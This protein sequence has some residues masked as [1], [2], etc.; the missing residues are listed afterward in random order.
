MITSVT[1]NNIA[2]W[3]W[4]HTIN[5]NEWINI[6]DW[7]RGA[8]KS[9]LL[10]DS[11]Q[12]VLT[13]TSRTTSFENIITKGEEEGSIQLYFTWVD[14]EKYKF[15]WYHKLKSIK[16]IKDKKTWL[17]KET[18]V[19]AKTIWEVL[20]WD[21]TKKEYEKSFKSP[22]QV[23]GIPYSIASKT[24][25]VKQKDIEGFSKAGPTEK[26]DI[27]A[28]SF[29][30]S[31]LFSIWEKASEK[32][33]KL[34]I[35]KNT[36]L[37]DLK[38]INTAD[39]DKLVEIEKSYNSLKK[40]QEKILLEENT[41]SKSREGFRNLQFEY[42]QIILK[43]DTIK[44]NE[45]LIIEF[46]KINLKEVEDK[47]KE[48]K[49]KIE[50]EWNDEIEKLENKFIILKSK[51]DHL[52][53]TY[54]SKI[55]EL[56][57]MKNMRERNFIQELTN[58]QK[59]FIET[60]ISNSEVFTEEY[61]Q[62]LEK[63][64]SD[65]LSTNL[66]KVNENLQNLLSNLK[67]LNYKIEENTNIIEK[68]KSLKESSCPTCYRE[69]SEE[70]KK[71][72]IKQFDSTKKEKEKE[73][74]VLEKEKEKLLKSKQDLEENITN[75]WLYEKYKENKKY[76]EDWKTKQAEYQKFKTEEEEK[77]TKLK[78]ESRKEIWN[79]TSEVV[80]LQ[81]KIEE[82]KEKSKVERYKEE[83][84]EIEFKT[85]LIW[86]KTYTREEIK[87]TIR[88]FKDQIREYKETIK[89]KEQELKIESNKDYTEILTNKIEE[90]NSK[91][92][93]LQEEKNNKSEE[94]FNLNTQITKLKG[95]KERYDK[96]KDK[97]ESLN[98]NLEVLEKIWTIFWKKWHPKTIIEQ[99]IIP[100]L[101]LKTNQILKDITD[102]NYNVK[103]S[104]SS[105]TADWRESKKNIFDIIVFI[106][107]IEQ[108]YDSISG[109]EQMLVNYAMRL[110]ITECLNEILGKKVSD[111]LVLDEAFTAVESRLNAE[112]IL[113]SI[114][115]TSK[116]FKQ[117]FIITHETEL[118]EGL[119]WSST[120]FPI[121]KEG[122]YSK[123]LD[124]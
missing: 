15:Y 67:V 118:K 12:I 122:R 119:Q 74:L 41:L 81:T 31:T 45:D 66:V 18:T 117:I 10:V 16:K 62:K 90:I 8:W 101:E 94:I 6:L 52:Q 49:E 113:T 102:W 114:K 24:F 79:M 98:W 82:L 36:L 104:L 107:W 100:Q 91:L 14:W 3:K 70:E 92:I 20:E 25:I 34:I 84:K 32:I 72:I 123:I 61:C 120:I 13:N 30:I 55:K 56:E 1:V 60:K 75:I 57:S 17:D 64:K 86:D 54:D 39:F 9:S 103:F 121:V 19:W 33:K 93:K 58:L 44:K 51:K 109:W 99:M 35:E 69:L 77:I 68:I 116:L 40:E 124:N 28:D 21:D 106:E 73:I 63:L 46:E 26:Y 97:I 4:E 43:K 59:K 80:K 83:L 112:Q 105:T 27:I 78:E 7:I 111:I 38:D 95:Y 5:Y 2:R 53:E 88:I 85:Y 87:S 37:D 115:K 29:N 23:L 42:N 47:I 89:T 71:I 50:K 76:W 48:L 108:S 65:E 22:E 11:L 110:W 96:V